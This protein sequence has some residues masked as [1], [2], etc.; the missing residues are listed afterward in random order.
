[1]PGTGDRP[2]PENRIRELKTSIDKYLS[3]AE[4]PTGEALADMTRAVHEL[5]DHVVELDRRFERAKATLPEW[6]TEGW[7]S[8]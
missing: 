2:N 3:G 7:T 5:A 4:E 1:M 8:P 6:T